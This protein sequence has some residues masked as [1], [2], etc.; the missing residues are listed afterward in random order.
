MSK[1]LI[2][3]DS[4]CDLEP[5][6]REKYNII[7][8]PLH[9]NY[10]KSSHLDNVDIT[11]DDI[12]KKFAETGELPKTAATS[13]G[14]YKDFFEKYID[15]GYEIIHVNLGSGLSA[16]YQNVCILS[17][18]LP[19]IH[20]VDSRNLSTG[21]GMIA[22]LASQLASEGK[23]VEEILPV[24]EDYGK[25]IHG[26]FILDKLNFLAAGGR[27]SSLVA[28]GAN[29]LNL[30]PC[31]EISY[32]ECGKMTVG[33]KYRGKYEESM[34]QYI[35]YKLSLFE[36]IIPDKVYFTHAGIDKDIVE[37]IEQFLRDKNMFSEV[38]TSRASCTISSHCGP[39]TGG[40]FFVT[41]K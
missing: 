24:I 33:K 36:G 40:I 12:Y 23:T 20:P 39:N 3:S 13:V 4:T 38:I 25:R 1:I 8:L 10:D 41:E 22:I 35:D 32:E 34:K 29:L 16:C 27:C 31:I 7:T 19:Q 37:N 28:L 11:P 14:E 6:V 18:E 2:T 17:K 15:D 30:K 21:T 26:S 9:V 5:E